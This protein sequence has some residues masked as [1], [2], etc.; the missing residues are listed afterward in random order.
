MTSTFIRVVSPVIKSVWSF[1]K[2]CHPF[3]FPLESSFSCF[4]S[5]TFTRTS[6]QL[7]SCTKQNN[8]AE[9]KINDYVSFVPDLGR[10]PFFFSCLLNASDFVFRQNKMF[11]NI[12]FMN[13][14]TNKI[15]EK[16]PTIPCKPISSRMIMNT[17]RTM[18]PGSNTTL[19]GSGQAKVPLPLEFLVH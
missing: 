3:K 14:S 15:P 11:P 8:N 1:A 19:V 12:S 17:R 13:P 2:I 5:I 6:D 16:N 7:R 9:Y 18:G 4:C 10:R